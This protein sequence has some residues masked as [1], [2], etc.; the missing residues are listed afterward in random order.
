VVSRYFDQTNFVENWRFGDR[1]KDEEV[2]PFAVPRFPRT[3][4]EYLNGVTDARFRIVEVREPQPTLQACEV[5]PRFVRWRELRAFL[6][7]V[8]AER[9]A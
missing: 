2:V 7:M 9:L 5:A 6:L 8:R 4:S 1:P 3:I